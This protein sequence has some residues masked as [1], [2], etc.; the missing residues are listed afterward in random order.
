MTAAPD[1]PN[2]TGPSRRTL[3]ALA[4]VIALVHL[5]L[6]LGVAALP[7]WARRYEDQDFDEQL[8]LGGSNLVLNGV[9][10]RAVLQVA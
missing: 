10:I 8:Q 7:S 2:R 1:A 4:L 6:L 3:T 5:A 9:G